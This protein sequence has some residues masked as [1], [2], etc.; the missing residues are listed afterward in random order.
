[1]LSDHLCVTLLLRSYHLC[2]KQ[3]H[4]KGK[5]Q[6][7]LQGSVSQVVSAELN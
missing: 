4:L 2:V 6:A 5:L 7:K 3:G 1:M